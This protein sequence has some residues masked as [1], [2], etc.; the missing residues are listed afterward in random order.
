MRGKSI[1]IF[2]ILNEKKRIRSRGDAVRRRVRVRNFVS[3]HFE[4]ASREKGE[5]GGD[6]Y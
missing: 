2:I 1:E 5:V 3:T 6:L 4:K